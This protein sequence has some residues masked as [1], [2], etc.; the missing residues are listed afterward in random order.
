MRTLVLLS[1]ALPPALLALPALAEDIP[2]ASRVSAATVFPQGAALTRT[3]SF[4][5]PAGQHQLILTDMPL[6]D[7]GLR[8]EVSGAVMGAVTVRQNFVPPRNDQDS[9]AIEAARDRVEAARQALQSGRDAVQTLKLEAEAARARIEFL[10]KLGDGKA[11]AEATPEQLRALSRM[12]GEETLDAQRAAQQAQIRAREA[13]EAL[14]DR[15]EALADA[16][17]ALAALDLDR[18]PRSYMAVDISADSPVDGE[19]VIRYITPDAWW[20]PV[21]DFHL[22]R[23]PVAKMTVGRGA[24][25]GQSTGESWDDIALTLSTVRPSGQTMPGELY[26]WLRRILDK[27]QPVPTP[28]MAQKFGAADAA[29]PVMEAP[30]MMEEAQASFDGLS[31]TYTYGPAVDIATDADDLR[32]TLGTLEVTP[33]VTALAVPLRDQT[34]YLMA[35]F[36][37]ESGELL[38]P[39][40]QS[41]FYLDGTYVG[42]R[43]T[44]LIAEGDHVDLSFGPIEG[45]RLKRVVK[46]RNEGDRGVIT[47]ENRL[48]ERVEIEIR[49]LTGEAWDLRLLDQV[50]YSEQEDLEIDWTA[51]PQPTE[52]DVD[53]DRGVLAWTFPL[54]AGATQTVTLDHRIT[55]PTDK[56]LR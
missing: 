12:V 55:W 25:V 8:I 3:A 53:G 38:A 7:S 6:V 26:P 2:V 56:I 44:E 15:I 11:L 39:T 20:Q 42:T 33:E 32:I 14:K 21:Y 29:A 31:V 34:A 1:L 4:S 45:I 51:S 48:D 36:D 30:V 17:K 24:Y 46:D 10:S 49:N 9:A 41:E 47:R 37:N 28:R 22:D 13:E 18:G 5:A 43:P 16:Q 23:K 54:A 52:T 35:G 50:P 19:V 40:A 27:D